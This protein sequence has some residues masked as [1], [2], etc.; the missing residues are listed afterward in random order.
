M[1]AKW[2]FLISNFWANPLSRLT[3]L[4]YPSLPIRQPFFQPG[5]IEGLALTPHRHPRNQTLP[6]GYRFNCTTSPPGKKKFKVRKP[7]VDKG[8][9]KGEKNFIRSKIYSMSHSR[10]LQYL[11][12]KFYRMRSIRKRAERERPKR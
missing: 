8:Q 10:E 2:V 4:P 3:T 1:I 11:S 6:E 9:G 5:S 7:L 12:L